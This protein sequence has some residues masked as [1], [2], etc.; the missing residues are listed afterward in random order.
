MLGLFCYS[1]YGSRITVEYLTQIS[2][3]FLDT[4][5]YSARMWTDFRVRV[6]EQE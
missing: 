5:C 2:S 4:Y 1:I 6:S 3:K